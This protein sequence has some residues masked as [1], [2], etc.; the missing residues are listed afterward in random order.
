MKNK[1][2]LV[3]FAAMIL[4]GAPVARS[5]EAVPPVRP[6]TVT[7]QGYE[8]GSHRSK[9]LFTLER[10][11]AADRRSGHSTFKDLEGKV[12]VTEEMTYD[13][14]GNLTA[15]EVK[16]AQ[17]GTQGKV[18]SVGSELVF[19][20]DGKVEKEKLPPNWVVGPAIVPLLASRWE[21]VLQGEHIPVR[22]ASWERQETI[23]FEL[24]KDRVEGDRIFVKMKPSNFLISALVSPIYFEMPSDGRTVFSVVGRVLPK[25]QDGSKLKDLDAEVVYQIK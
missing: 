10:I 22:L 16:H 21:T 7:G 2:G 8:I 14:S 18:E 25:R 5:E 6:I 19:T 13:A 24:F 23:G 12:L 11:F 1:S 4:T 20:R 9:L 15:Y 17:A 3:F